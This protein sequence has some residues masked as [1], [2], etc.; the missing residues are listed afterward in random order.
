LGMA[1]GWWFSSPNPDDPSVPTI[2]EPQVP[3]QTGTQDQASPPTND[4]TGDELDSRHDNLDGYA[5]LGDKDQGSGSILEGAA[6]DPNAAG[7]G[8]AGPTG[9]VAAVEPVPESKGL[10]TARPTTHEPEATT[11]DQ[12]ARVRLTGD[13]G[14][15]ALKNRATGERYPATRSVP[16]GSYDVLVFFPGRD[17]EVVA[18][19]VE[20]KAGARVSLAC[21]ADFQRCG[22]QQ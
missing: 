4:P 8:G 21:H 22:L 15:A 9:D 17:A 11:G 13:A 5:D 7:A 19:Q 14:R 2:D 12:L 6:P 3:T 1:G 10:A 16:P 18:A 20:L